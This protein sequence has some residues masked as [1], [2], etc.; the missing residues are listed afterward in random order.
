MVEYLLIVAFVMGVLFVV[1]KPALIK[2]SGKISK[3]LQ[4]GIFKDDPTGEGFY[5]FN[6]K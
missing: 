5:R 2:F 4:A 3:S 1:A 6:I